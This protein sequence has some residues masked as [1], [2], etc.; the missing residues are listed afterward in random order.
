M[1]SEAERGTKLSLAGRVAL[2]GRYRRVARPRLSTSTNAHSRLPSVIVTGVPRTVTR[3]DPF[4][5]SMR[6]NTY[7][8]LAE[9]PVSL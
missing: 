2:T 6:S 3:T 5:L 9:R 1:A 8:A 4:S 7:S